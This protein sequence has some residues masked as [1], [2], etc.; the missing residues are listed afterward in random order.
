MAEENTAPATVAVED[1]TPV[2]APEPKKQAAPKRQKAAAETVRTTKAPAAK[3]VSKT[4]KFSEEEKLEKLELIEAQIADGAS[5]LK[6]AVKRAGISEQTYY[7]WKS[8]LKKVGSQKADS[9]KVTS[10]KIGSKKTAE[11]APAG[12]EFAELVQLEAENERLRK[13]L[14]EKLRAENSDLRK[15]LGLD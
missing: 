13:L 14:S 15:R 12:D 6:G 1:A 2:K 11:P 4:R 8:S 10:Q 9:K 5:T 3:A 7:N